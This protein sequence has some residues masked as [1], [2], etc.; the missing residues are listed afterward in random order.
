MYFI[1]LLSY[2]SVVLLFYCLIVLLSY[3][4]MRRAQ[5]VLNFVVGSPRL[6][7]SSSS[8]AIMNGSAKFAWTIPDESDRIPTDLP[9]EVQFGHVVQLLKVRMT[10]SQEMSLITQLHRH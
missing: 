5:R 2:C 6:I 7:S 10:P 8:L 4:L 3:C 9:G 1:V